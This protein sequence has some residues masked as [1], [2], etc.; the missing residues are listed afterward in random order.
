MGVQL[1]GG[2]LLEI[3]QTDLS[4]GVLAV[5]LVEGVVVF[6]LGA[7]LAIVYDDSYTLLATFARLPTNLKGGCEEP[8]RWFR[9]SL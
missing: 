9:Q 2:L 5:L 4:V 1:L 3:P 6:C 8:G 7:L